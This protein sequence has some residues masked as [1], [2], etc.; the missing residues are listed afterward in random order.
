MPVS[1]L[2]EQQRNRYGRFAAELS[3]EQL[4]RY[5]HLDDRD[6]RVIG[7]HRGDHN[8]LG[9]AIQLCTAR[10]L[11]VVVESKVLHCI[12]RSPYISLRF[13]NRRVGIPCAPFRLDPGW[14]GRD[15]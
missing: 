10:F 1:F 11:G 6:R 5:F 13:L 3:T 7:S 12:D 8:R 4:A 14:S 2:T 9:F 15:E